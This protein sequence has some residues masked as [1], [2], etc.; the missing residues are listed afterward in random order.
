M[1][2]IGG[3]IRRTRIKR[4]LTQE[5]LGAKIGVGKAQ[6]SKLEN[7][8]GNVTVSTIQKVFKAL[9]TPIKLSVSI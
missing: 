1:D 9:N 3:F 8:S 4:R 7:G 2:L 5:M 6:I